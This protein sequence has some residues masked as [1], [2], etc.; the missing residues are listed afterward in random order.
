MLHNLSSKVIE[1]FNHLPRWQKLLAM[2][3]HGADLLNQAYSGKQRESID[4]GAVLEI[5]QKMKD[6]FVDRPD[7]LIKIEKMD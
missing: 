1:V 5:L 3:P 6:H 7:L 2:T 4:T